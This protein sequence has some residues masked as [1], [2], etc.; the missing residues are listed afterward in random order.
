[1]S[2]PRPGSVARSPGRA[3]APSSAAASA[4]PAR[5]P[6]PRRPGPPGQSQDQDS[7]Q[8]QRKGKVSTTIDTEK[9]VA[10]RAMGIGL[11]GLNWL[12]GSDLLDRI[13]IRKGVER[14]LFQGT[15]S[16]FRTV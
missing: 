10:D 11:R 9:S 2:S 16:G 6:P 8:S 3:P 1:M 13:R 5:R 4:I 15:K 14:A 12:A 7:V